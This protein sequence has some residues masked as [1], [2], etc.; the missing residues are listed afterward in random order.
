MIGS[1]KGLGYLIWTMQQVG[2]TGAVIASM[3]VIGLI[4][5]LISYLLL[6]IEKRLLR[7]RQEVAV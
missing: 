5:F 4:G 6:M 3:L 7:W 1:N 2:W